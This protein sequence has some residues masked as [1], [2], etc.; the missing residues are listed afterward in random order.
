MT[1]LIMSRSKYAPLLEGL[2]CW[3]HTIM[4]KVTTC[5]QPLDMMQ[6]EVLA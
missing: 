1:A 3:H 5:N 4:P 2:H 6:Q